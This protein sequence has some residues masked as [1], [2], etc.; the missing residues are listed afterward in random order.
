MTESLAAMNP[1]TCMGRE[2]VYF[3]DSVLEPGVRVLSRIEK[4]VEYH[5]ALRFIAEDSRI[6]SP[7]TDLL[8]EAPVLFKD[9]INYKMSGGQGFEPHQDI[10]AGWDVYA[11]YFISVLITIDASTLGNGCLELAAGHHRRGL[12]GEMWKPLA[13]ESLNGLV[14]VPYP[15]AAGDVAFFDCFTPHRSAP[16]RMLASRRNL[17]LTYNRK[18]TGDHRLRYYADKRRS[19]PPDHERAPGKTYTYKV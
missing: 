1:Q 8:G 19:F 7:L 11:D 5:P 12:L 17:Y 4:F 3:E 16:N 18:S 10:Q 13:G 2:M 15:L 6:I 9:K 14:F